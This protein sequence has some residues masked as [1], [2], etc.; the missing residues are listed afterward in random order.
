MIKRCEDCTHVTARDRLFGE[1]KYTC[2]IRNCEVAASSVC[3]QFVQDGNK[4]LQ[5]A[6]FRCHEFGSKDACDSCAHR[7]S[8]Q[9]KAGVTYCCKKNNVRFWPGFSPM[10]YICNNFE[11]GGIDALAGY[12]A[13]LMIEED[14]LKKEGK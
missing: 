7:E 11:D 6:G 4:V 8:I 9:G 3:H 14:R 12:M 2:S 13:D 10:D 5:Y 1:K